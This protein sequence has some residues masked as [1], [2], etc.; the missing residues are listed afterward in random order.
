MSNATVIS[1]VMLLFVSLGMFAT[2]E[3]TISPNLTPTELKINKLMMIAMVISMAGIA[4][5]LFLLITDMVN[6]L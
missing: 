2:K 4:V 1:L 6:Y 3:A 5:S